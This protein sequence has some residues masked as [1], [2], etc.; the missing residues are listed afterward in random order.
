MPSVLQHISGQTAIEG[1]VIH[2]VC[3]ASVT[4]SATP[5]ATPSSFFLLC[6]LFSSRSLTTNILA[7]A[8]Q[9]FGQFKKINK[10]PGGVR[11]PWGEILPSK[12]SLRFLSAERSSLLWVGR[13]ALV[14]S[15][16]LRHQAWHRRRRVA[17]GWHT[18]HS[19]QP[20]RQCCCMLLYSVLPLLIVAYITSIFD[21]F[22]PLCWH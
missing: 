19:R 3:M 4:D 14:P 8:T 11:D 20:L 13:F 6:C 2:A 12:Q 17:I 10:F 18:V 7:W 5:L 16:T 21:L 22:F 9:L 15:S 1:T